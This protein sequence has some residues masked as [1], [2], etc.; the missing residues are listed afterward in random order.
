MPSSNR[1]QIQ[2]DGI[3]QSLPITLTRLAGMENHPNTHHQKLF[4][5]TFKHPIL[6][7]TSMF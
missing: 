1:F 4:Q 2:Q 6:Q 7:S 5:L 3:V